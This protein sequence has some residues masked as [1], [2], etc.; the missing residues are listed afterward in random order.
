MWKQ[1]QIWDIKEKILAA[2][3]IRGVWAMEVNMFL[4]ISRLEKCVVVALPGRD[5]G[6]VRNKTNIYAL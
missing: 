5:M 3:L 2:N 1:K 4:Q 6:F